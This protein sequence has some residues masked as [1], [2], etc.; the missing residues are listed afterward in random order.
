MS[1]AAPGSGP[2]PSTGCSQLQAANILA[3]VAPH[4]LPEVGLLESSPRHCSVRRSCNQLR[5]SALA[6]YGLGAVLKSQIR[7]WCRRPESGACGLGS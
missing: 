7:R 5:E 4:P 1:L 2:L 3:V 6:G